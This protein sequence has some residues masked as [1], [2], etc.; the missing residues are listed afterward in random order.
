MAY[1]QYILLYNDSCFSRDK[2]LDGLKEQAL[3]IP[4][5]VI[6]I[7][8]IILNI[9]NGKDRGC[10]KV[11]LF[12]SIQVSLETTQER[13]MDKHC[14]TAART[15]FGRMLVLSLSTAC[16]TVHGQKVRKRVQVL[17]CGSGLIKHSTR[18]IR[19]LP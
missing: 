6:I 12:I 13:L 5:K 10:S 1:E 8:Y 4:D 2:L 16:Y 7:Q 15:R 9:E 18:R 14:T 11:V 17:V 19:G 3:A